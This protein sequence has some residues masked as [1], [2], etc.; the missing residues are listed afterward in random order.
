MIDRT[1]PARAPSVTLR[2]PPPPGGEELDER[3]D[4]PPPRG[5][6]R[7]EDMICDAVR[8]AV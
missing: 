5:V 7:V 3:D 6:A 8:A 2:V 1:K 4:T